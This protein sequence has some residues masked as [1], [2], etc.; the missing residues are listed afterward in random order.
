MSRY[1]EVA[2]KPFEYFTKSAVFG[3]FEQPNSPDR[4]KA[5]PYQNRRQRALCQLQVLRGE[6][7][8]VVIVTEL[9]D[10]PGTS[11]T[12]GAEELATKVVADLSLDPRC[13][14][15]IERYT[16]DSYERKNP[17]DGETFDEVTFR[18]KEKTASNPRWRRLQ[19][20]EIAAL[21]GV[22]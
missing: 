15:F 16:P 22:D 9:P 19:P 7:H 20:L 5:I 4:P 11:V 13:T 6:N 3:L 10:N 21:R 12:N 2:N 8:T 18:W 17:H 1:K 14:R